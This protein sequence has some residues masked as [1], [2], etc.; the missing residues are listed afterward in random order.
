MAIQDIN[1]YAHLSDEDIRDIGSRLAA[2]EK[3]HRDALGAGDADY[4][5]SLIRAQRTL[6]L[7]ARIAT[8]SSST[9]AVP[10]GMMLAMAKILENLE[11]GHNVMHGQWDWMNDPEIH[12]STWE[13]DNT[14]PSSGWKHSHNV[15]HHT[16]TNIV[17]MDNDI[18]YGVL[19]VTRDR[20]WTPMAAF[21]PLINIV[22]A[23]LFEVAVG[24]Y[25]VDLGRYFAG[26]QT[27]EETKPRLLDTVKKVGRQVGKDYVLFPAVA[28]AVGYLLPGKNRS[29]AAEAQKRA[30]AA[31]KT[32]VIGNI[33]R[34]VWAYA[35][36]FCG[37]FPDDVETF[38]KRT[39][40]EEN[41]D[42]W[43]LRQMLGSAN[44]RGGHVLS[45]L[46]GNL[47][48]QIEHHLFPDMP[49]NHLA[50]I[51]AAVEEIA[52][53]YGLPY[54]TDSFPKQLMQVQRTL[55]KLSL[56]N[57]MLRAD[58]ANAPEV[59]SDAAFTQNPEIAEATGPR[60]LK[61][62]LA[63]LKKARPRFLA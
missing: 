49:S 52:S 39:L 16:Y 13:W 7:I 41:R 44:F 14:G 23:S 38:T 21:Q 10:A 15:V 42:E 29:R 26:R 47:N 18:G 32:A 28:A 4:I 20:K 12:S 2:I 58:A 30:K 48:H 1:A 25:D 3:E 45:I 54:N 61:K 63:L 59:R 55:L 19:R 57:N 36:I 60:Q 8:A 6:D 37:H 50:S 33:T 5:K 22:L 9:V 62:G 27:W 24:F 43:Y 56:P 53:E 11:I 51:S 35:V 40:E 17:G 46:S 34:N 31:V